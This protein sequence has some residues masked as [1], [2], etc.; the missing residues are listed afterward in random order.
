[1]S[2]PADYMYDDFDRL[3]YRPLR[4]ILEYA[5]MYWG[6]FRPVKIR[7]QTPACGQSPQAR[8]PGKH[9]VALACAGLQSPPPVPVKR[10]LM[11]TVSNAEAK[12][13]QGAWRSF[14][15]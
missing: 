14:L 2:I 13:V 1:M 5:Y 15:V 8:L 7:R 4:V 3:M 9:L 6:V 12:Y 10:P 11:K